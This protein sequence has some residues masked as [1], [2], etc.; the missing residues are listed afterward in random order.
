MKTESITPRKLKKAIE[1]SYGIIVRVAKRAGCSTKTVSRKL[2]KYPELA[3]ALE[4]EKATLRKD[5]SDMADLVILEAL[6]DNDRRVAMWIK[7]RLGAS[8]G[9]NPTLEL[10]GNTT[11]NITLNFIDK[12]GDKFEGKKKE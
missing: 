6:Q 12:E 11:E 10:K 8:E 9:Y 5:L 7:E 1:G 2:K 4:E 3:E